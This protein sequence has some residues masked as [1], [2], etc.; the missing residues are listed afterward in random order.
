MTLM[1]QSPSNHVCASSQAT[2]S[3]GWLPLSSRANSGAACC[4]CGHKVG[5]HNMFSY[6]YFFALGAVTGQPAKQERNFAQEFLLW[7]YFLLTFC[8]LFST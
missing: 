3:H 5:W 7:A 2:G 6:F 8:F 1:M 4:A